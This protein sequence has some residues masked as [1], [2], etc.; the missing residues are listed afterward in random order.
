[1]YG[2]L[3][4]IAG[5]PRIWRLALVLKLLIFNVLYCVIDFSAE[6]SGSDP[7][8]ASPAVLEASPP[9]LLKMLLP[10]TVRSTAKQ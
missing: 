7:D 1:M 10:L 3:E 9:F 5:I 4:F 2:N 6:S 8:A